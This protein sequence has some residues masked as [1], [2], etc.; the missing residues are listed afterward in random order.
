MRVIGRA[1]GSKGMLLKEVLHIQMTPAE[2]CWD[3]N[4]GLELPRCWIATLKAL[5]GEVGI[6]ISPPLTTCAQTLRMTKALSRNVGRVLS[7]VE[8]GT[9]EPL[10]FIQWI[11]LRI[12]CFIIKNLFRSEP[13]STISWTY[14]SPEWK[15][16]WHLLLWW[17]HVS[18]LFVSFLSF[19]L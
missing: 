11:Q 4:G 17:L 15:G 10:V 14:V 7:K 6:N 18:D 5:G 9:K 19:F 3:H 16:Q 13:A 8:A 2:R 1:K 12:Y